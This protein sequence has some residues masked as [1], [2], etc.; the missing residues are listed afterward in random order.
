MASKSIPKSGIKRLLKEVLW[1]AGKVS[2]KRKRV[3]CISLN[4]LYPLIHRITT[5]FQALLKPYKIR[6]LLDE[7]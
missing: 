4:P 2:F 7:T 3:V 6:V 1:V 5:A